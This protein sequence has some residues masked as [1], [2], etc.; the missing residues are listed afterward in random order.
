MLRFFSSLYL[1][2]VSQQGSLGEACN[3]MSLHVESFGAAAAA[4]LRATWV[5]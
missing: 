4:E 3:N 1:R 5:R 2:S